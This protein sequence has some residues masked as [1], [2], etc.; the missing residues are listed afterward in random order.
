MDWNSLIVEPKSPV[1]LVLTIED[2]LMGKRWDHNLH[3]KKDDLLIRIVYRWQIWTLIKCFRQSKKKLSGSEARPR[4]LDKRVLRLSSRSGNQ[5]KFKREPRKQQLQY[6]LTPSGSG[7]KS[8]VLSLNW[9]QEKTTETTGLIEASRVITT[10]RMPI[11]C[12]FSA[13]W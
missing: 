8:A 10:L 1:K 2:Y 12:D 13:V 5:E 3:L 6:R 4:N 9:L 11:E 7:G